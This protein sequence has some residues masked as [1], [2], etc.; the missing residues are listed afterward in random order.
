MRQSL[1]KWRNIRN[2]SKIQWSSLSTI[3]YSYGKSGH[4]KIN[5]PQFDPWRGTS[6]QWRCQTS[7]APAPA[8]AGLTDEVAAG[9]F[10][11]TTSQVTITAH[12]EQAD[13][14]QLFTALK[15]NPIHPLRRLLPSESSIVTIPHPFQSTLLWATLRK[16]TV[17]LM[18]AIL[19]T[20]HCTKTV[21]VFQ[22]FTVLFSNCLTAGVSISLI[23]E[24]WF[25]AA[26]LS[27]NTAA[28]SSRIGYRTNTSKQPIFSE[29][30]FHLQRLHRTRLTSVFWV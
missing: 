28:I 17:V 14:E 3:A 8:V 9:C 22:C 18:S 7:I 4:Q 21:S 6:T 16:K 1:N 23:L 20:V 29:G 13:N 30:S 24:N 15:Y 11:R 19:F 27:V 25:P 12:C 26:W 10:C 5:W 2:I